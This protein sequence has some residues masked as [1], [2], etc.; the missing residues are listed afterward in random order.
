MVAGFFEVFED[1]VHS[2]RCRAAADLRSE[3]LVN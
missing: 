3:G 1:A 2:V